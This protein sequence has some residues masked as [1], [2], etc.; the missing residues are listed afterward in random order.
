MQVDKLFKKNLH[1]SAVLFT[2][3]MIPYFFAIFIVKIA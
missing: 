1:K 3:T 2:L